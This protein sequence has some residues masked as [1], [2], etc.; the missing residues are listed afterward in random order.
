MTFRSRDFLAAAQCAAVCADDKKA[1]DIHLL[2]VKRH[3]NLAD[4]YILATADSHPQI[5][6]VR[7]LIDDRFKNKFGLTPIHRDGRDSA[8]WLVMDYG[9]LVIH[10]MDEH[11]RQYYALERL[12]ENARLIDWHK[13]VRHKTVSKKTTKTTVRP[14]RKKHKK[15]NSTFS[16]GSTCEQKS[17]YSS[18]HG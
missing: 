15:N 14:L 5:Q 16:T 9:G 18:K 11:A 12:W 7:K 8:H 3:S 17:S 10:I 2:D 1:K 4:Y 6:A 13:P